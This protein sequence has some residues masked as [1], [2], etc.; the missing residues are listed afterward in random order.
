MNEYQVLMVSAAFA[1]AYSLVATRLE[2]TPVNGALV[3]VALGLFLGPAGLGFVKFNFGS[4]G[5]R[6][7]AEVTLAVVL[8]TDSATSNLSVLRR[9]EFIPARLLLIGLPLTILFGFGLAVL[10]FPNSGFFSLALLATMLAPTDA[11]L[12]QAVVSNPKVP[13]AVR[14][15][16]N[17]ESGL[18]DGICVPVM[19]LFLSMAEG[20][21]GRWGV[22]GDG[23]LFSLKAIGIGGAVGLGLGFIGSRAVQLSQKRGWTGG[24]WMEIPVVALAL[25]CF[26]S[27]QWLGGSGFIASFIGGMTF[28]ALTQSHKQA[29]LEAAEGT[30]NALALITWFL[31]GTLLFE[32][33]F[34]GLTWQVLAYALGSLTVVRILPVF[35]SVLGLHLRFDTRLFLGWFGPRGL[36]SIVFAVMVA[37]AA[38]PGGE[39]VVST[40]AWTVVLSIVLHGLSANPMAGIYGRRV[41]DQ[42][43]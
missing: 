29:L 26:A 22:L 28:G 41:G 32:Y 19:L 13:E 27:A 17:V 4:Q 7:L 34:D 31:F 6:W 30:G 15:S 9:Y 24:S 43:V 33:P 23:V 12:G 40:A 18:N 20:E 39:V 2:R 14:E 36:A 1:F 25:L 5:M 8:F 38:I 21:T 11:A 42:K 37:D 35:L 3:Y 10:L 16:L